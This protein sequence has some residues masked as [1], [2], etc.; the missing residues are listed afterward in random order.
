MSARPFVTKV[1]EVAAINHPSR[2]HNSG[3]DASDAQAPVQEPAAHLS[4]YL[5]RERLSPWS[6]SRTKR[7]FDCVCVLLAMPLL[8]PISL[9]VAL[10]IR[11]TS[12]GPVLFLQERMGRHGS[13]FTILKFR[14]MKHCEGGAQNVIT[15]TKNQQF[16]SIGPFL[17][18]WKLDE[19]PQ[20]LNVLLGDMSLVGSRPKVLEHQIADLS[21][22]PGI[23]G[24]ATIAFAREEQILASLPDLHL[25]DYYLT[26][27]L[28]LKHKLDVEYMARATFSSDLKLI[29]NSAL[30]RWDSSVMDCLLN[31]ETF[32]TEDGMRI[33]RAIV[34]TASSARLP[35]ISSDE[36]LI[37]ADQFTE[38]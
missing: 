33:S 38:S 31:T 15:T 32:E 3:Q 30:R 8:I 2:F 6:T 9:A 29:V 25:D 24:G 18:R 35:A 7:L 21:C 34:Q 36:S 14:T 12:R 1:L 10:A 13:I 22:R 28:P 17:R 37:P 19:L 20:L 11:F 4:L 16:T 26:V 23:T 27:I 5:V